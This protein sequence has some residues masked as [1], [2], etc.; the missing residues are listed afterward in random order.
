MSGGVQERE[1]TKTGLSARPL[2]PSLLVSLWLPVIVWCGVIFGLSAIPHLRFF[3]EDLLDFIVRKAGHLG[4]YAI[5]ARLLARAFMG[6]TYASWKRIFAWS[7][8][9]SFLYACSDEYHQ[10]FVAGRH[11]SVQDVAIDTLGSW[12][13]LG[14]KP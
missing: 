5:L 13:A 7:L 12:L 3:N 9:L 8:T 11:A 2:A 1:N 4:V 14:L 10:S 6:S